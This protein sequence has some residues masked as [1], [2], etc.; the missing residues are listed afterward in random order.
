MQPGTWQ[1]YTA[2]SA[3]TRNEGCATAPRPSGARQ[4]DGED[5]ASSTSRELSLPVVEV[6]QAPFPSFATH[7]RNG[8]G[9]M[10]ALAA[11]AVL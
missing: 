4:K 3:S 2:A 8:A 5:P 11:M 10:V 1:F 7:A 9:L 6:A